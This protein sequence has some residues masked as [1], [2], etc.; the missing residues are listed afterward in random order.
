MKV[1]EID[2]QTWNN[3]ATQHLHQP[4]ALLDG[5]GSMCCLGFDALACGYTRDQLRGH[6]TPSQLATAHTILPGYE[7][8]VRTITVALMN[9]NTI[10]ASDAMELNDDPEISKAARE[11]KLI[12]ILKELGGYDDVR[13]IN[14][15]PTGTKDDP[16]VDKN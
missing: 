8:R 4:T 15:Y 14:D 16:D 9:C 2:R 6:Q 12:P 1:L 7:T 10:L 13:F 5:S 3:A 11:A